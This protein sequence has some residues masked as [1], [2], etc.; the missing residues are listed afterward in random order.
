MAV[1]PNTVVSTERELLTALDSKKM[2]IVIENEEFYWEVR[3]KVL[4]T[5]KAK[6]SK[7]VGKVGMAIS[8]GVCLITG[9]IPVLAAGLF[10]GSSVFTALSSKRDAFKGYKIY[11][12]YDRHLIALIKSTFDKNKDKITGFDVDT[13]S[14]IEIK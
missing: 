8:V 13:L 1:Y 6:T 3:E 4:K 14:K 12:D 5:K 7:S 2:C 9:V 11:I 10:C